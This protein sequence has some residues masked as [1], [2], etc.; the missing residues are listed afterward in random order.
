MSK[1]DPFG[2]ATLGLDGL[3]E[4]VAAL[5][6]R[7]AA[8]ETENAALRDENARLKGLNSALRNWAFSDSALR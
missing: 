1:L 4:L 2:L 3:R 6:E 8:L 7:V 5:L